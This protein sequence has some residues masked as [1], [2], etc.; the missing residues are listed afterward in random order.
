MSNR[1]VALQQA[2][3][4]IA[5]R[6]M[7][8]A[9]FVCAAPAADQVLCEACR[10]ALPAVATAC[11]PHCALDSP[12]G[13][14][15][16]R[17]LSQPPRFDATRAVFRYA[18]PV[19][20]LVQA[21]KFQAR[22]GVGRYFAEQLVAAAHG[23]QIDA[24]LPAP[25]HPHRLATR[26]FN[27]SVLLA[28]PVAKALGVPHLRDAVRK[29]RRVAPQAGL[30]LDERRRNLRGAFA[31]QRRFDGMRMLVI[32]DV[33]TSGTTLDELAGAL[34]EAGAARVE[35]L[36]VARTPAGPA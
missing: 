8:Q 36:V 11:C 21:Y 31:V 30:T 4:R 15:C 13:A 22:F 24:V 25:L 1:I 23:L 6:L 14:V 12:G 5:G 17:C 35:A 7:P 33:M 9:C 19:S 27:Q 34:K 10:A 28:E 16:G 32:D 29:V 3:R 2:W 20:E 26:G 18:F